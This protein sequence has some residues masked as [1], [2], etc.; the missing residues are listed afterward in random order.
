MLYE[1]M[2]KKKK[3]QEESVSI[4]SREVLEG[5]SYMHKHEVIHRDLKP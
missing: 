4:I 1:L 2:K 5:V 3:F